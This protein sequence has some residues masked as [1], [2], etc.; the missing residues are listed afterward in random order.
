MKNNVNWEKLAKYFTDELPQEERQEVEKTLQ[1]DPELKNFIISLQSL[2]SHARSRGE[3]CDL[4]SEWAA[5]TLRTSIGEKKP[6]QERHTRRF[7]SYAETRRSHGLSSP[8]RTVFRAA[9]MILLIIGIAFFSY[10]VGNDRYDL[11]DDP[12]Q[13]AMREISTQKGQRVNIRFSDGTKV[14]LNA[15]STLRFPERFTGGVREVHLEGEAYFDVINQN[16]NQFIVRAGVTTI[17]VL[18]TQFNVRAWAEDKQVEVVVAEGMVAF[19][20]EDDMPEDGVTITRGFRSSILHDGSIASPKPVS[21][22]TYLAWLDGKL[23][24]DRTPVRDVFKQLE[25]NYNM[26]FVVNEPSFYERQ[27]TATFSEESIDE[28]LQAL[29][30]SL[31]ARFEREGRRVILVENE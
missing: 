3:Q 16:N 7:Q 8:Y 10:Q 27:I 13:L 24:F 9:A 15:A 12:E 25:R 4:E 29:S 30:I 17:E 11:A 2:R 14:S 20:T 22:N 18:G 28:I 21:L 6:E 31:N 1:K 19:R 23:I 26:E 5:F